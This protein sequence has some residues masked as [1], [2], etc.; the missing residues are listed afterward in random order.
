M[1]QRIKLL[2]DECI[3]APMMEQLKSLIEQS[4]T[5]SVDFKHLLEFQ[6]QGVEDK[7]WLPQKAKEGWVLITADRGRP[8]GSQ[9][10]GNLPRLCRTYQMTH[11]LLGPSIHKKKQFDKMRALLAVWDDVII[12]CRAKPGTRFVICMG[13]KRP[14]LEKRD[15]QSK[16][17]QKKRKKRS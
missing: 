6:Q 2:F 3:G 14:R 10:G 7:D 1:S 4:S 13:P 15:V 5:E 11:I 12:A 16:R 8:T 17:N 9:Q